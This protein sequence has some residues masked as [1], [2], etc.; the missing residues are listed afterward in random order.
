MPFRSCTDEDYDYISIKSGGAVAK[1]IDWTERVKGM[2]K[3]ELKR[4]NV[5]YAQLVEK[6]AEIGVK[7]TEPNIRTRSLGAALLLCFSFNV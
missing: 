1:E 7:E 2:L 3:V 4:R 5:G 6:L